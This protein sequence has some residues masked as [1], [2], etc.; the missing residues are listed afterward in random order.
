MLSF[1]VLGTLIS[2]PAFAGKKLER[3]LWS[4]FLAK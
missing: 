4:G 3:I 2:A 1:L